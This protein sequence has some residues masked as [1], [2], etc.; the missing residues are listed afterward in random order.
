MGQSWMINQQGEHG[1]GDTS[2]GHKEHTEDF[3]VG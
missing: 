1:R 3:D 2:A